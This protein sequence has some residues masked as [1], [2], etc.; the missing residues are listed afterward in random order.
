MLQRTTF[1]G[2]LVFVL[3]AV[4]LGQTTTGTIVGTITDPSQAAIA[5]VAVT[6]T[7]VDT[8]IARSVTTNAVGEFIVPSLLPGVRT[9]SRRPH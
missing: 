7:N 2:A 9:S 8:G 6:I 4:G 1:V 3:A 5:G